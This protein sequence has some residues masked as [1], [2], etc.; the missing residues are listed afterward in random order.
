[1]KLRVCQIK[2][3]IK[4]DWKVNDASLVRDLN[5]KGGLWGLL[6]FGKRIN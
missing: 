1:M 6:P 5:R 2:N 4:D 3:L